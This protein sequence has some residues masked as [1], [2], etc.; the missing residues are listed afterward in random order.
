MLGCE[1]FK[2]HDHREL[3]ERWRSVES[4]SLITLHKIDYAFA[5]N[6][7]SVNPHAL[8]EVDKMR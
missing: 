5:G 1:V 4:E 3:K 6:H 2:R 8:A 7:H